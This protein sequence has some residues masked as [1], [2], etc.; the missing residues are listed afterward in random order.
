MV[1]LITN[2]AITDVKVSKFSKFSIYHVG[3][4][5]YFSTLIETLVKWINNIWKGGTWLCVACHKNTGML[6]STPQN[7]Y[8]VKT[9]ASHNL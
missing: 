6:I 2:H 8:S 4:P 1:R 9:E 5:F 7:V 3:L